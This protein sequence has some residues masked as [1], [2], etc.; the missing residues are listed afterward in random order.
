MSYPHLSP[1]TANACSRAAYDYDS[2]CYCVL[3]WGYADYLPRL[4]YKYRPTKWLEVAVWRAA[5]PEQPDRYVT[6]VAGESGPELL[7]K[8][9]GA[10]AA[11]TA[12]QQPD[13]SILPPA[14]PPVAP[15]PQP[16]CP[17]HGNGWIASAPQTT[18]ELR[19]WPG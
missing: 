13:P 7:R 19:C 16:H 9:C 8:L 14:P 2:D 12:G 10:L 17:P 5:G 3:H 6:A 18:K 15:L 4:K 1:E 11:I